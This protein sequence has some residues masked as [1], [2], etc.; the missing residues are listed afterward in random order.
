MS[1]RSSFSTPIALLAAG[2]LFLEIL[3]GSILTTAVP[4]IAADFGVRPTDVGIVL[5]AYLIAAA[6]GIP[7]AGW[8][9]DRFGVR[10]VLLG[11]LVV[12]TL[13]SGLCALAPDLTV[14][15]AARVLQ[16]LG[17]ALIVPVGRLAVIRGIR[18]EDLLDAIAYLTWPALVAP[19]IA[20]ALGGV[21]ADTI[22]W[23]WI[24]LI[25]VP[26]GVIAVVVGLLVLPHGTQRRPGPFD[27]TGFIGVM[28]VMVCITASAE[29]LSAGAPRSGAWALCLLGCALVA[30]M[31]VIRWLRVPGR[32]FDLSVFRLASFRVGNV[33]GSVYRLVITAAPFLFTLLFQISFGWS[34]TA[35]GTMVVALFLGNVAVK[36]LTTPIIRRWGFRAVL[37]FSN[38]AGA[39]TL[40]AFVLVG[41]GTP[42]VLIGVLLF[43][44][45]VFRSL[46]FSA[47]NT[48]QFADLDA[49][50]LP[51]A[52]V[53]SAT[54]HQLGMSL[55]IAV[56][57]LCTQLA[58]SMNIAFLLA[59]A[60]FLFPL[61][62][63]LLLDS[64]AGGRALT[65]ISKG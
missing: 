4:A 15:S 23:R 5:V 60:L 30:G 65:K 64:D 41:P 43:L 31:L 1:S 8:L 20:P 16:G 58:P 35:A 3:D 56:A 61:I 14:L 44:S 11:A 27:W 52:N 49:E 51:H 62:G 10:R 17:G 40:A 63:S 19:V 2:A 22:G 47:Y 38:A 29:M 18:P 37:V 42:L 34:A 9:A 13:A 25:N 59:A 55:G 28:V 53:L 54:L 46:G 24:F 6:A 26:L 36:P 32:L 21:I 39:A 7:A 48:L 50:S 45:G 57:V 33:S 12:F